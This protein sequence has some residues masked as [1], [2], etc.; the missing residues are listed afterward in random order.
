M[1][2]PACDKKCALQL[3]QK[4]LTDTEFQ[5]VGK[6]E[7]N[8]W[9]KWLHGQERNQAQQKAGQAAFARAQDAEAAAANIFDVL[10]AASDE[11]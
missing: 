2:S 6:N 11:V 3:T 9:W 7:R 8:F 1:L 5:P 10:A 4:R